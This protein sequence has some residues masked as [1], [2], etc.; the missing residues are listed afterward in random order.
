MCEYLCTYCTCMC[1]CFQR[2]TSAVLQSVCLS[3]ERWTVASS[4]IIQQF[5]RFLLSFFFLSFAW[6]SKPCLLRLFIN[7]FDGAL[8]ILPVEIH[9]PGGMGRSLSRLPFMS[10]GPAQKTSD[11]VAF[12][13]FS[14]VISHLF[15]QVHWKEL[16]RRSL[17]H[18]RERI[19][20]IYKISLETCTERINKICKMFYSVRRKWLKSTVHIYTCGMTAKMHD[21]NPNDSS[22]CCRIKTFHLQ[23]LI[24]AGTNNWFILIAT[25]WVT[26]WYVHE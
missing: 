21:N 25:Y 12:V 2:H 8:I 16:P 17:M 13:F 4:S 14:H 26:V 3:L 10:L 6:H 23:N 9:S 7:A 11:T 1:G 24:C 5:Y 20:S 22:T 19:I 18:G 15:S